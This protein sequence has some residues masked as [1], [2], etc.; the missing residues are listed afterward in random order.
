M[1]IYSC[2]FVQIFELSSKNTKD[3][4]EYFQME[5]DTL[6]VIYNFNSESGTMSFIILNKLNVPLYVDWRKSSFINNDFKNNYWDD[7]IETNTI[8]KNIRFPTSQNLNTDLWNLSSIGLSAFA[9]TSTK[10]ERITFIPPSTLIPQNK[11]ILYSKSYF[12][13]RAKPEVKEQNVNKGK[14]CKIEFENYNE[15]NSPFFFRNFLTFSTSE[16]FKSEFYLDNSFYVSSIK[17]VKSEFLDNF[18]SPKTFFIKNKSNPKQYEKDL[19]D[20]LYR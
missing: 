17:R 2:S 3:K 15:K 11:F 9:S 7:I 4:D 18:Q 5:N 19:S 20:P 14:V 8:G 10:P 13:F 6:K 16:N 12:P 1:T